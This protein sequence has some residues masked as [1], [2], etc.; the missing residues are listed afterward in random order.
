MKNN[1]RLFWIEPE[2]NTTP[3]PHPKY[4]LKDPNGLLA[5]GGNLSSKR[6]LM[7]YQQGIFPWY[8]DDRLILWWSPSPRGVLFPHKL[9]IS[10]SLRKN[11][12][13]NHWMIY[14]DRDFQQTIQNC[15]FI[16]RKSEAGTWIT[17]NMQ[18]AYIHMHQL[19]YA[20]SLE[21]WQ[22]D[23]MIGGLYGIAIDQVFY[24]ESMFSKVT[25]AS[26]TALLGLVYF[27]QQ[28]NFK[29]IDIQQDTDHLRSLGSEILSQA[30]FLE[31]LEK[32]AQDTAP[33]YWQ[34]AIESA[35]LSYFIPQR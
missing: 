4:A 21:V 30:I 35:Q 25:D 16:K 26:K 24:G 11:M 22:E 32:W 17:Q 33:Q 12:R 28:N 3:F 23:N 14:A 20:H 5:M 34:L 27:L 1:M 6:L 8:N 9:K 19:G 18:Q 29:L 2:D 7:A 15:A 13:K 10:R 31:S